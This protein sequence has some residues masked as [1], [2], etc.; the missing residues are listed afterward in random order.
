M[1]GPE[2][3]TGSRI[4]MAGPELLPGSRVSRRQNDCEGILKE[5][6]IK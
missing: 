5:F 3:P 4:S 1:A 2:L 6:K